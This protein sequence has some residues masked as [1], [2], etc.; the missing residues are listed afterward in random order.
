MIEAKEI[1]KNLI[2]KSNGLN[3][4]QLSKHLLSNE[5]TKDISTT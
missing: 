5:S 2:Y 3:S 4:K 1:I